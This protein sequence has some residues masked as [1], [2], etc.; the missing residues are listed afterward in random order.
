MRW[1]RDPLCSGPYPQSFESIE[2]T[3]RNY[4]KT[5]YGKSPNTPQ[6]IEAEFQKQDVFRDLGLSKF[7]ERGLLFNKI[8]I[9]KDYC[10]CI[11]SSE[12]SIALV[13]ENLEVD[14][15]FFIMDGT[16]RI[17]PRGAFQQ[18]LIIHIQFGIRVSE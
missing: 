16:F 6:E 11:F 1:H 17:T 8:C 3:L 5:K 15:R 10:N 4:R 9:E 12:K 2:R 14:E 18:V 7:R 13:K